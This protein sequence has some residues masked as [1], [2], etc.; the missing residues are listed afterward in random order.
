MDGCATNRQP[1]ADDKTEDKSHC[2]FSLLGWLVM[3][4]SAVAV[5]RPAAA[6]L[7]YAKISSRN[8]TRL[9]VAGTCPVL[10]LFDPE[11]RRKCEIEEKFKAKKLKTPD[12]P[13]PGSLLGIA[14][15]AIGATAD[16]HTQRGRGPH[17]VGTQR[18]QP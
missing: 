6:S 7:L 2:L 5:A 11:V 3:T 17:G 13:G 10:R 8:I 15:S 1:D 9:H 16:Q 12:F 14:A 18:R 4:L